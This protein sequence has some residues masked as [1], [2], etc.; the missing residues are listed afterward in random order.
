MTTTLA[1]PPPI[2]DEGAR[3]M[4]PTRETA[5]WPYVE[6][7]RAWRDLRAEIEAGPMREGERR[8]ERR[9][10]V[11]EQTLVVHA[12]EHRQLDMTFD[13]GAES[14]PPFAR[15]VAQGLALLT[16]CL[17][18][19]DRLRLAPDRA[20]EIYQLQAEL[21]LDQMIGRTLAE[22]LSSEIE[23]LE[24]GGHAEADRVRGFR[25]K[26]HRGVEIAAR[27]VAEAE[28]ELAELRTRAV[29]Q[30]ADELDDL[31]SQIESA[32]PPVRRRTSV[33]ELEELD[34]AAELRIAQQR[35][36]EARLAALRRRRERLLEQ[37][38]SRTGT[39]ALAFL[40][41]TLIWAYVAVV[42]RWQES[43]VGTVTL[44]DL[45]YRSAER[46]ATF[47]ALPPSLFVTVERRDWEAM[48]PIE[49]QLLI[50][51]IGDAIGVAGFTG[52]FVQDEAS[53]PLARWSRERGA[54]L[55]QRTERS[56]DPENPD[57]PD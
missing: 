38:P 20:Q 10:H 51:D 54:R 24:E 3:D 47:D 11:G 4:G 26:L 14:I 56:Q 12:W 6:K 32:A 16:K 55:V 27:G 57:R 43:P 25:D 34:P 49:R 53:V 5:L 29:L 33:E 46:V 35:E 7:L 8:S 50:D 44:E 2:P 48:P 17:D 23:R 31:S 36:R 42:P 30:T 37:M 13:A 28:R 45:R 39:L 21:M 15:Q 9:I 18:D 22:E 41:A 19:L 52:A 40:A 1:E